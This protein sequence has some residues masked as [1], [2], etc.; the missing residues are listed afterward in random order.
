MASGRIKRYY[1]REAGQ[2]VAA[3]VQ[4]ISLHETG[5]LFSALCSSDALRRQL[6]SGEDSSEDTMDVTLMEA[7]AECCHAASRW[8]T[9]RHILSMVA[10]SFHQ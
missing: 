4:D 2:G 5:P 1:T 3:V 8:E 9:R 7:L 10:S 6:S